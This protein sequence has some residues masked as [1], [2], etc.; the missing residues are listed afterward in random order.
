MISP[1]D[2]CQD[3]DELINLLDTRQQ[4]EQLDE[5]TKPLKESTE[6]KTTSEQ[7]KTMPTTIRQQPDP[8]KIPACI[9]HGSFC[10]PDDIGAFL[11]SSTQPIIHPPKTVIP[12]QRRIPVHM[13]N[14]T[15]YI[16]QQRMLQPVNGTATAIVEYNPVILSLYKTLANGTTISD[17]DDK[18]LSYITGRYHPDFTDE[19]ADRVKYISVE[20]STNHHSCG[21][22]LRQRNDQS[23]E[24]C[25]FAFALLDEKL[26]T[27]PGTEVVVDLDHY[28]IWRYISKTKIAKDQCTFHDVYIF[29]ARTSKDN[30]KKDQMFLFSSNA[31]SGTVM[32]PIDIRRTPHFIEDDEGWDTKLVG[33]PLPREMYDDGTMYGD[34]LQFRLVE[35]GKNKKHGCCFVKFIREHGGFVD[36]RKNYHV[37]ESSDGRTWLETQPMGPRTTALTNL[38]FDKGLSSLD[39]LDFFPNTTLNLSNRNTRRVYDTENFKTF[40]SMH[41]RPKTPSFTSITIDRYMLPR[42]G[43]VQFRGTACCIDLTMEVD[44]KK[45]QVVKVGVGHT[46]TNER[47]YLSFFYAFLP[48]PPFHSVA[49]SG[50]FCLGGIKPSDNG[51]SRHWVSQ[52]SREL[53]G[54]TMVVRNETYS[55]PKVSFPSGIT[56]MV[57]SAD[58]VILS[59]GVSDCYSRSI[60]IGKEKIRLLLE[61]RR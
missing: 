17:I 43:R 25:M 30:A 24:Q 58:N 39:S 10:R 19:D 32:I 23:A 40:F 34:G 4:K 37:F 6:T 50:Y 28:Y 8:I 42:R 18:L 53:F 60:I 33:S 38:F 16:I 36:F 47:A 49:Y 61:R 7:A 5:T 35:E 46:V 13:A 12:S 57:G 1:F 41:R 59:Y 51:S 52:Q 55:C 44:N 20:R 21:V 11:E 15:D 2:Y 48:D 3:D 22:G 31:D 26:D 27:I 29:A 9:Q 45:D 56:E 54:N 14:N